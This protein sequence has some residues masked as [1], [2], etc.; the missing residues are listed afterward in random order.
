MH[1]KRIV[2]A[3]ALVA[4]TLG[5]AV[6]STASASGV[7][8]ILKTKM[9]GINEFPGPGDPNGKG[10]FAAVLS[11]HTMCYSFYAKKIGAPVASHIHDADAGASGPVIITF[12]LPTEEGVQECKTAVPDGEDTN[13]TMSVSELAALKAAPHGFYVNVHTSA[14]P[15]GAIRGQL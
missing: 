5:I 9:K 2:L 7:N 4:G 6:P 10:E 14:F 15:A 12:M 1:R 3:V 11:D 13:V 8:E